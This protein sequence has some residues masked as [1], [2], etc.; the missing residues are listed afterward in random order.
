MKRF[1]KKTY[2]D[3]LSNKNNT[4]KNNLTFLDK[5]LSNYQEIKNALTEEL[6]KNRQTIKQIFNGATRILIVTIEDKRANN[7]MIYR[8]FYYLADLDVVQDHYSDNYNGYYDKAI[9]L[10]EFFSNIGLPQDNTIDTSTTL[11]FAIEIM[12]T[13]I[14][15]MFNRNNYHSWKEVKKDLVNISET[16]MIPDC[17][18]NH[19]RYKKRML[20]KTQ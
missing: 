15:D 20:K 17:R 10:R 18:E 6:E 9:D 19:Q 14:D 12:R 5:N 7:Q 13:I 2:I 1:A 4:L 8:H 11:W 3:S 16:Y